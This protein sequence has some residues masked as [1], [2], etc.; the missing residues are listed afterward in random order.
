MCKENFFG[1]RTS[2]RINV[3]WNY[4]SLYLKYMSKVL[5]EIEKTSCFSFS[6]NFD[7]SVSFYTSWESLITQNWKLPKLEFTFSYDKTN[8]SLI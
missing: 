6:E 3:L 8:F 5:N 4:F 2:K 7:K 1:P